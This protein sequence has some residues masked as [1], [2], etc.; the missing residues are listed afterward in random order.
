MKQQVI[1]G[2]VLPFPRERLVRRLRIQPSPMKRLPMGAELRAFIEG[3]GRKEG[4]R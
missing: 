4:R 3:M 2:V 1:R